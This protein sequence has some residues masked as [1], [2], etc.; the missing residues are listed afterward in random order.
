[1]VMLDVIIRTYRDR[2]ILRSDAADLDD[3]LHRTVHRSVYQTVQRFGGVTQH[4]PQH[5]HV[6]A[7][8]DTD[9]NPIGHTQGRVAGR[10]A[11]DI[12]ENQGLCLA[13]SVTQPAFDL[14][15]AV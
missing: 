6:H 7:R 4:T 10:C 15:R 9:A 11:E 14:L 8:D 5:G 2:L 12:A 13:H 3:A 1:M